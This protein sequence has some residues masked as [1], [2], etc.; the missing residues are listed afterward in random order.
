[1]KYLVRSCLVCLMVL[2]L[3]IVLLCFLCFTESQQ[4]QE[5]FFF[6]LKVLPPTNDSLSSQGKN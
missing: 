5:I 6:F 1:M 4:L 2:S 3:E